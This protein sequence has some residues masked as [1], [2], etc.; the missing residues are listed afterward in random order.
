MSL[1]INLILKELKLF[2]KTIL[3]EAFYLNFS[4]SAML[5]F[6]KGIII[7]KLE[8]ERTDTKVDS[9]EANPI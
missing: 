8:D 1:N 2:K 7:N 6:Y 4:I 9:L 5:K 3:S